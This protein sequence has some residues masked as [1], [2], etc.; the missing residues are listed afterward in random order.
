MEEK[1]KEEEKIDWNCS[2][3]VNLDMTCFEAF[4]QENGFLVVN[5]LITRSGE[6]M[7]HR[8]SRLPIEDVE[9]EALA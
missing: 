4:D 6:V 8:G 5:C 7:K 2:V 9:E 1:K 3:P